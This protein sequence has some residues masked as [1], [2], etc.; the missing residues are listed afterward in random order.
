[1]QIF[2]YPIW[3]NIKF[4]WQSDDPEEGEREKAADRTTFAF[5]WVSTE[6]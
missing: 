5:L 3:E 6:L 2:I 1:M 4:V